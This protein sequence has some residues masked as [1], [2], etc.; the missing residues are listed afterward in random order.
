MLRCL[1]LLIMLPALSLAQITP[2]KIHE[3]S[4]PYG[5]CEPSIAINPNNPEELVSIDTIDLSIESSPTW[6]EGVLRRFWLGTEKVRPGQA[7]TVQVEWETWRGESRRSAHAIQIPEAMQPGSR[8]S[9]AVADSSWLSRYRG[10]W[11]DVVQSP[12]RLMADWAAERPAT[13]YTIL[14]LQHNP[15]LRVDE[16]LLDG[17]PASMQRRVGGSRDFGPAGD[18]TIVAEEWVGLD[19]VF[20]GHDRQVLTLADR[21][22]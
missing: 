14:L 9:I 15:A 3:A 12:E 5:P 4:S 10:Q 21:L 20:R 13:G 16:Q 18:F 6:D 8:Y 17:L 11:S 2:V 1:L 22:R 7:L 19:T